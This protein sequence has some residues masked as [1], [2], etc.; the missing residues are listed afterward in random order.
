MELPPLYALGFAVGMTVV[1]LVLFRV[2]QRALSGSNVAKD[3]AESNAARHLHEV[4]QVLAVFFVAAATVKN[5]VQGKDLTHDLLWS[6]GFGVLG[7]VLVGVTGRLGTQLLLRSAL[8]NEI[9]RGNVAAGVAAG[10]HY[11]A[12]GIV[13]A[14]AIAWSKLHDVGLSL[15]FFLIAMATLWVFVSMFR[16][17]TTYD[18]AEQIRG[19]N[20]A[21]A[22]S[23]AGLTIAVAIIVASALEG[24]F[25]SWAVSMKGYGGILLFAFALYPVRQIFV[26]TL[27]LG[28]PLTF[29]GGRLDMGIGAD[30]NEGIGALEAAT[31]VATALAVARLL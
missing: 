14:N 1:L 16:A 18:D 26:Q 25:E 19:E 7:L 8:P 15:V 20:L 10:S 4:G 3:F 12:T 5:N 11:V 28:A 30:R 23:Y 17:L 2:A 6:G 9:R 21:A 22:L 27:L 13:T 31:Y 29:R 24:D